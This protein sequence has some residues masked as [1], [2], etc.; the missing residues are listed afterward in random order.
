[1]IYVSKSS[2]SL[3]H[4]RSN[5]FLIAITAVF[6]L[7]TKHGG[8]DDDDWKIEMRTWPPKSLL[9]APKKLRNNISS[10]VLLPFDHHSQKKKEGG[11]SVAA[12]GG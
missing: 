2:D 9:A 12:E 7:L 3:K 11:C 1:M 6:S 10:K 8:F 5:G 4:N